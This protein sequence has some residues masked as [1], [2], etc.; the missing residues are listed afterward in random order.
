ML[1]IEPQSLLWADGDVLKTS[2]NVDDF[3]VRERNFIIAPSIADYFCLISKI[4]WH[5]W[6]VDISRKWRF[7][8][9]QLMIWFMHVCTR[10]A[11]DAVCFDKSTEMQIFQCTPSSSLICYFLF[12]IAVW[13]PCW[14]PSACAPHERVMLLPLEG[15]SGSLNWP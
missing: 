4:I 14:R 10:N 2:P 7:H 15:A 9:S 3:R 11:F 13:L 6:A 12:L 1:L 5:I 8:E